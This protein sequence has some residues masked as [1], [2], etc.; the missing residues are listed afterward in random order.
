MSPPRAS[1]TRLDQQASRFKRRLL[2]IGNPNVGKS[3]LF[4]ALT[5]L[6]ATVSNY[7]GTT[8]EIRRGALWTDPTTE[9]IDAPGLNSL[10]ALTE[11]E[12]VTVALLKQARAQEGTVVVQVAD[13][14]N[15]RRALLLTLQLAIVRL[16]VVLCLNMFDEAGLR[17][18][19]IDQEGLAKDL[20][21]SICPTVAIRHEGVTAL[22][23]ALSEARCPRP[24]ALDAEIE[25]EV[26]Q[27]VAQAGADASLAH[28]AR[29]NEA[30]L[31]EADRLVERHAR[32]T[33]AESAAPASCSRRLRRGLER[34]SAHPVWGW[35]ILIFILFLVYEFVGVLGAGVLVDLL[36]NGLFEGVLNPRFQSAFAKIPIPI[37]ADFFVGPYG[38]ITVGLTYG[39]AIILPI[40]TT[41]FL[42]FA[43][44]EDSGYLPRLAIMLDHAFRLIGLNGKA[45][46][47][48]VLGLGCD[49][50]ATMTTRIL[51]THKERVLATL[52]LALGVPC[53]A[54]LGVVLA[55]LAAVPLSAGLVWLGM[56]LIVIVTVGF[57]ASRLLPGRR[58]AFVVELPPLR[59]PG[60]KNILSKTAARVEWYLREALPLFLLGT[61]VLF[62]CERLN[63][64]KAVIRIGEPI[65]TGFLGLP[66]E[67]SAAFLVGFLR[68]DFAATRLFDMSRHGALDT[69]QLVVAMVTITLFIPC[70]A[71]VF[72]MIKERG[73]KTALWISLVV[74][75][76]AL[77]AGGLTNVLMRALGL[78]SG[79]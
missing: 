31:A 45:V 79:P 62:V 61:I 75:P 16:P 47:P 30:L 2:L 7:A 33:A 54:Q 15:L 73:L 22:L 34:V 20:G 1:E 58:G 71:H 44:L 63:I 43:W 28:S 18:I 27:A 69:I 36:E 8:V 76:L 70:I 60:L 41:F 32:A 67:A 35:P 59:W 25:R 17:G 11:D 78:W 51:T 53:S 10:I 19:E 74:F 39:L 13:A 6:H 48:M 12:Q 38:V 9:V 5:G 4:Q 66:A 3:A 29:V 21:I 50:M 46:L 24:R 56:I 42:A 65:V 52:L 14:K 77:L 40:V 55:M 68:R 72:M 49:T 57:L 64:L 37:V 23:T 26:R